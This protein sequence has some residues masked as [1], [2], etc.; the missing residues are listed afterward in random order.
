MLCYIPN[1][2]KF[3][4]WGSETCS[5]LGQRERA[6]GN[7]DWS[8]SEWLHKLPLLP[9]SRLSLSATPYQRE[10]SCVIC[11]VETATQCS[12]LSITSQAFQPLAR[13][14]FSSSYRGCQPRTPSKSMV[15]WQWSH[16]P[17]FLSAQDL[18][19]CNLSKWVV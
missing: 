8:F 2:L 7:R 15:S 5:V 19:R 14:M 10:I 17:K 9:F 11:M 12:T 3:S 1:Q 18:S 4:V 16:L 6:R 13:K